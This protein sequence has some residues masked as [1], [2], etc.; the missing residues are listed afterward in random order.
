[1]KYP[2]LFLFLLLAYCSHTQQQK[3]NVL[4]IIADDLTATAVSSYENQTCKTPNIDRLAAQGTK[5]TRAYSQYPVCGPSRAS[6]MF[7][8]YPHA[9]KTYGYVSGREN[10]GPNRKSM[11]QIFKDQGYYAAMMLLND[12]ADAMQPTIISRMGDQQWAVTTPGWFFV[13]QSDDQQRLFLKPDDINDF[14]DVSRLRVDVVDKFN[15]IGVQIAG[16]DHRA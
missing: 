3:P 13:H 1:M 8:Y 10:V 16:I 14:N 15:S 6:L 4:F 2:T 12:D 7:G 11:S 9:T 5:Y